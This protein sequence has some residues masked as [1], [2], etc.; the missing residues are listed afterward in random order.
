[1]ASASTAPGP[2]RRHAYEEQAAVF[3]DPICRFAAASM[4][5]RTDGSRRPF[6]YA[7]TQRHSE[8]DMAPAPNQTHQHRP[9]FRGFDQSVTQM[10]GADM[11]LL[12]GMLVPILMIVGLV[13]LL[14]QYPATW[15]VG[16][17][18][19]LEIGGLALVVT[20]ILEMM[21]DDENDQGQRWS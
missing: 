18:V 1:V 11:R 3:T 6:A 10:L 2:P 17:I 16:A 7:A 4:Q 13:I 15:L 5:L 9:I 19:I 8:A 21:S 12:Y 14:T 20:A